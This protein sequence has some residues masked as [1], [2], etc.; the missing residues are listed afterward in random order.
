MSKTHAERDWCVLTPGHEGPCLAD[1]EKKHRDHQLMFQNWRGRRYIACTAMG[2]FIKVIENLGTEDG[3]QLP[4]PNRAFNPVPPKAIR[5]Q[6]Q[7]QAQA[8]LNLVL[9]LNDGRGTI[10]KTKLGPARNLQW[11]PAT[12]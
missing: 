12:L 11:S 8:M 7:A 9:A 3:S 10:I 2:D 5:D 4:Q 1:W 6:L